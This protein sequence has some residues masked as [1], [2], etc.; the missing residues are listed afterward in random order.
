MVIVK[1][2]AVV[3]VVAVVVDDDDDVATGVVVIEASVGAS[4]EMDVGSTELPLADVA[5]VEL[6]ELEAVWWSEPT[7]G[8]EALKLPD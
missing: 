4:V 7:S 8:L 1:G 5:S 3:G 2:V 6:E